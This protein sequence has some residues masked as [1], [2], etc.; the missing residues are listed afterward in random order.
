MKNVISNLLYVVIGLTLF[1]QLSSAQSGLVQRIEQPIVNF[2]KA[3]EG[4]RSVAY[5]DPVG[6]MTIGYGH[7]KTAKP[8]MRITKSEAEKLLRKDAERFEKYVSRK[9]GRILPWYQFGAL[10]SFSY[11]LGYRFKGEFLRGI[12]TGN[13]DLVTHKMS[14]YIYAGG[15]VLRGLVIRRKEEISIYKNDKTILKRYS[16]CK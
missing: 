15:R 5:K 1:V 13:H 12:Q 10:V 7:I 4:F 11:N 16:G 6:V 2:I 3:K 14:L 8:G 9:A